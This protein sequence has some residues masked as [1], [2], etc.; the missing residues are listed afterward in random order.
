[1]TPG[2][3]IELTID[4]ERVVWT[5]AFRGFTPRGRELAAVLERLVRPQDAPAQTPS[6]TRWVARRIDELEDPRLEL[7][8]VRP[9]PEESAYPASAVA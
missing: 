8:L 6:L 5:G 9:A 1:M 3:R 2:P 4:G 7:G